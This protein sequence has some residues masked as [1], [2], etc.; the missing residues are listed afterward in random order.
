MVGEQSYVRVPIMNITLRHVF[1]VFDTVAIWLFSKISGLLFV[2]FLTTA[3]PLLLLWVIQGSYA[4]FEQLVVP[5][6]G[7]YVR[8]PIALGPYL[9]P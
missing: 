8:N 1:G 5:F 7:P 4:G 9:V 3:S 2:G 6:S